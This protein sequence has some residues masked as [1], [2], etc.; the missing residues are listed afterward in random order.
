MLFRLGQVY[1]FCKAN[2]IKPIDLGF[3]G[4]HVLALQIGYSKRV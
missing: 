4:Y 2:P 3:M 1:P